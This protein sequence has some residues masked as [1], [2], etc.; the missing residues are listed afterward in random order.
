MQTQT[1]DPAATTGMEMR[2]PAADAALLQPVVF[3]KE[4]INVQ[5]APMD[6]KQREIRAEVLRLQTEYGRYVAYGLRLQV[7]AS[8]RRV[9]LFVSSVLGGQESKLSLVGLQ[10]VERSLFLFRVK[11]EKLQQE[12]E[13]LQQPPSQKRAA[14]E[15]ATS[16]ES[17][18]RLKHELKPLETTPSS[19]KIDISPTTLSP[20]TQRVLALPG[21]SPSS[22]MTPGRR[23][24][25]NTISETTAEA[26]AMRIAENQQKLSFVTSPGRGVFGHGIMEEPIKFCTLNAQEP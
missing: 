7:P 4:Y 22:V 10:R 19:G 11:V 1:G 20:A 18:K 8:T 25:L 2:H 12:Q 13:Q 26:I 15:Q 9:L 5:N 6:E 24:V 17:P 23:T 21:V 3:E 14:E 16:V